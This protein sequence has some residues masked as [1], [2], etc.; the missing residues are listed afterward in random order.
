MI[1]IMYK[2]C[3]GVIYTYLMCSDLRRLAANVVFFRRLVART[4]LGD[5]LTGPGTL[6]VGQAAS[7]MVPVFF[8]LLH[9]ELSY[10]TGH[11]RHYFVFA[12]VY[13]LLRQDHLL[14]L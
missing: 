7:P 5:A 10:H 6:G 8:P 13:L 2:V 14:K 3:H 1:I 4:T 9:D 12:H 11:L